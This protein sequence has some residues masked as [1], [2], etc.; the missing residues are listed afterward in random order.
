MRL[1]DLIEA[2]DPWER[3]LLDVAAGVTVDRAKAAQARELQR[4]H[5]ILALLAFAGG[6]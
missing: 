6:M 1:S 5:P 4:D 3:A 2:T